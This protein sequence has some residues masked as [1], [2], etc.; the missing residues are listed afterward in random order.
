M[1]HDRLDNDIWM[2]RFKSGDESALKDV[3]EM[4]GSSLF[5]FANNM[6][7]DAQQSNDIVAESFIKL[8]KQRATFVELRNI[9]AYLEVITRNACMQYLKQ[10]KSKAGAHEELIY[11]ENE[12]Y[13]EAL[14]R[15][16][17][18]D[19][20]KII[21]E[22][23]EKLPELARKIF[24]MT[25]VDGLKPEEIARQLEMPAQNIQHNNTRTLETL[26]GSLAKKNLFIGMLLLQVICTHLMVTK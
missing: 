18:S 14:N 23:I 8:W 3:F 13:D 11:L 25:F 10:A 17:Y 5:T 1:N 16:L 7:G 24:K 20:L 6:I 2:H 19:Y 22:E 4:Y 15:I 12:K 9:R 21:F 26:R